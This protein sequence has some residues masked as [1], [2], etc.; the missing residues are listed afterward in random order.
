MQSS[1]YKTIQKEYKEEEYSGCSSYQLCNIIEYIY[2][3]EDDIPQQLIQLSQ[4]YDEFISF[5]TVS[6]ERKIIVV[7]ILMIIILFIITLMKRILYK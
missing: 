2:N 1:G 7:S 3:N 4:K 6:I 5:A